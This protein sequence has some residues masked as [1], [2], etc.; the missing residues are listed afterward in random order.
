MTRERDIALT[1]DE[2]YGE[3]V[4][5]SKKRGYAE[6]FYADRDAWLELK[7]THTP[8]EAIDYNYECLF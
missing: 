2:W 6:W 1:P 4:R 5:I 8:L 3:V 7:E